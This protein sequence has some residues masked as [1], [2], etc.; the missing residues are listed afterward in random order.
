MANE[1]YLKEIK[2]RFEKAI[3]DRDK[4]AL[5]QILD[6]VFSEIERLREFSRMMFSKIGKLDLD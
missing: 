2:T 1:D 5:Y 6:I 3:E 4:D